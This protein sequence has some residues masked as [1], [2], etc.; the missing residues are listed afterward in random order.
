MA[1]G[2]LTCSQRRARGKLQRRSKENFSS[3][4]SQAGALAMTVRG[5]GSVVEQAA[6]AVRSL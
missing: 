2:E 3:F 1:Q 5:V 4:L 6:G